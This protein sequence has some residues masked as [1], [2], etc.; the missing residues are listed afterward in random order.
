MMKKAT[1]SLPD[2]FPIHELRNLNF[3]QADGHRDQYSEE[4]FIVTSSVKQFLQ[5]RH[6]LIVGAIGTGKSTLYKLLK[7]H[8]SELDEYKKDL[9]VPLEESLSFIE[10]SDLARD[11]FK[12]RDE[13]ILFQLIWKFNILLKI[14]IR[15]AKM[16]GFPA[17]ENEKRVN[18]FLRDSESNDTYTNIVT[19]IRN[20]ITGANLKIETKVSDFPI[21]FSAGLSERKT[22]AEKRINLEEIQRSISNA[23]QER[24][25][26]RAT[27]IIDRIDK[28]VAGIE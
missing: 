2:I 3:G 20:L 25:F 9:I 18:D 13:K 6:S 14:A 10:L 16:E 1:H 23:V 11:F 7:E 27:V 24:G 12:G 17:N 4:T 26:S 19:R 21:S 22:G 8:S 5:N 28:F 15:F